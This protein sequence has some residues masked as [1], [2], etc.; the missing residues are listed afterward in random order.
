MA[1]KR[2]Q[3]PAAP[4]LQLLLQ[5]A[6][7]YALEYI[8]GIDH[9][10]V[11]PSDADVDALAAFD[12]PLADAPSEPSEVLA[13]LHRKGSPSTVAQ[14]GGRYFGFVNG[15]ANPTAVAA[16]WLADV[17][18]QN[19]ALYVMS[20]AAACLE[21]T[22]EKWLV[23]LLDLPEDT[24]VGLVGG[25][26]VSILCG[27]AAGRN[28]LLR[29]AGWEVNSEGLFDAP[30]IRVLVGAQAHAAVFRALALLGLGRDRIE[31]VPADKQGRMLA[32]QLPDLDERCLIVTQAGNV[33]SGAFDPID[34]ICTRAR[35]VNA[36]VHV[37][38]AFGLWAGAA[39]R[40]RH[41]YRGIP[42]ADSWSADAH[43]T[44]N[45]PYDC[46]IVLCRDRKALA[47]AMQA[48]ASYLQ[49]SENRDNMMYTP[50]MSRRAR[51]VELW[52]TMKTLG[53]SGIE[54]LVDQLCD[55]AQYF[56]KQLHSRGFKILN[57][58]VFNQ[59]LV[60]CETP[61]L[62]RST[63]EYIQRSG[64]C[65]C[66]GA[67]WHDEPVIRISVCSWRTSVNDIDCAVE[68]FVKAREH[69]RRRPAG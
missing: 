35:V 7:Q 21:E 23:D 68:T 53:R 43:K 30:Q 32:D 10:P 63:L 69:S 42:E 1:G 48:S 12:E 49:W 20:P 31:T 60:A 36:W 62:T 2:D 27:L 13:L 19:A 50:D 67:M 55:H 14:T 41:L 4:D 25:S 57:E 46:G 51:A 45:A 16:K 22:C 59:V 47:G 24:A 61:D 9:R 17:W 65:W 5:R 52:A 44:L 58:V 6:H 56:S 39:E 54:A 11:Y 8:T 38:G 28:E 37:D 15:A 40:R 33:N 26:S 66:G 34:E 3:T 29:R 64:Q 18:D